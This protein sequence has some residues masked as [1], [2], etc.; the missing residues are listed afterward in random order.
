[1]ESWRNTGIDLLYDALALYG[2]A[3]AAATV[4]FF[5]DVMEY[6]GASITAAM[7]SG[8][9]TEDELERIGRH[10]A[11]KVV[12]DD[13]DG[14]IYGM[15]MSA[16][17][18]VYQMGMR[19][20]FYQTGVGMNHVDLDVPTG[21]DAF[22]YG[23]EGYSTGGYQVR[24]RR[25]PQGAETCDFCLMLASRGAVYLTEESAQGSSADDVNHVHQNCDCIVVPCLVHFDNGK[26]IEDTEIEGYDTD[27]LYTMWNEWKDI[28]AR[29][30]ISL[31]VKDELKRENMRARLGRDTW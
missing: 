29:T 4:D 15:A 3:A 17:N 24:Y 19:T 2:E 21:Q 10:Q 11:E 30:D 8:V 12:H 23:A 6:S 5:D 14:F 7:P 25:L 9:Y 26:L 18:I 27:T 28:S 1:M 22:I 16:G 20:M 31:E 13:I